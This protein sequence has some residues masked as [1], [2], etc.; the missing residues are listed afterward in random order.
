MAILK[1]LLRRPGRKNLLALN[2]LVL[3]TRHEHPPEVRIPPDALPVLTAFHHSKKYNKIEQSQI[4]ITW[5]SH[6]KGGE[7]FT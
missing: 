5:S 2:L 3:D 1:F 7:V 4:Q 6:D